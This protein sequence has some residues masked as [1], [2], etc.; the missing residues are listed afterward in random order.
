MIGNI[1][2]SWIR[3]EL[4]PSLGSTWVWHHL[5]PEAGQ[6]PEAFADRLALLDQGS[7]ILEI[8]MFWPGLPSDSF[9]LGLLDGQQS[10]LVGIPQV[11]N[12]P[13]D[14]DRLTPSDLYSWNPRWI[15]E[16]SDL[17]YPDQP[18]D[19]QLLCSDT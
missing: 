6:L 3:P 19:D 13:L 4:T 17:G 11:S 2:R 10:H 12:V 5:K 14:L 18:V 7:H 9:E 8:L 15:L 1:E 16:R